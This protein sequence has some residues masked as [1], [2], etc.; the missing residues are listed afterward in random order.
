MYPNPFNPVA[1]IEFNVPIKSN[2]SLYIY[3]LN[4]SKIRDLCKKEFN[5]GTHS[6]VWD[7]SNV[8]SGIYFLRMTANGFNSTQKLM[9]IK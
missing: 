4:G 9:L 7:A 3:N 6:V 2:V 1:T 5:P 8:P